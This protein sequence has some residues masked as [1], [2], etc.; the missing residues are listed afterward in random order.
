MTLVVPGNC[1]YGA[2]LTLYRGSCNLLALTNDWINKTFTVAIPTNGTYS[3]YFYATFDGAFY[4]TRRDL[5]FVVPSGDSYP[6]R[7]LFSSSPPA[8]SFPL[9]ISN[10]T[11]SISWICIYKNIMG[12]PVVT[13]NGT[14]LTPGNSYNY[15]NVTTNDTSYDTTPE[16][17]TLYF[18]HLREG[19]YV[20]RITVYGIDGS[21]MSDTVLVTVLP[22]EVNFDT[23]YGVFLEAAGYY[24]SNVIEQPI[25]ISGLHTNGSVAI[26]VG[27]WNNLPQPPP[28]GLNG[29]YIGIYAWN[30]QNLQLALHPFIITLP[31]PSSFNPTTDTLVWFSWNSTTSLWHIN[32]INSTDITPPIV[33]ITISHLSIYALV[34][35]DPIKFAKYDLATLSEML[36]ATSSFS[37]YKTREKQAILYKIDKVVKLFYGGYYTLAYDMLLHD[38]KPKLT[39]LKAYENGTPWGDGI[40]DNPWI[41]DPALRLMLRGEI[42]TALADIIACKINAIHDALG[43]IESDLITIKSVIDEHLDGTKKTRCDLL[44]SNATTIYSAML[45]AFQR[46]NTVYWSEI[47]KFHSIIARINRM[48]GNALIYQ[49]CSDS[50]NLLSRLIYTENKGSCNEWLHYSRHQDISVISSTHK[51][52]LIYYVNEKNCHL[53]L[54]ITS[55]VIREGVVR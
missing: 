38:I 2:G 45:T 20:A 5:G 16:N 28:A 29:I 13:I 8:I 30:Q 15:F 6:Q 46:N 10:N 53:H 24:A 17:I 42:D 31:L 34:I 37:W 22:G 19:E 36:N 44:I 9:A 11:H 3:I 14:S 48:A 25:A 51:C 40:F 35:Y 4:Q 41:T 55:I 43:S 1:Y 32:I 23:I 52:I 54:N 7:M 21:A 50:I 39:G 27:T 33:K 47:V 49:K 18:S 12:A 26:S